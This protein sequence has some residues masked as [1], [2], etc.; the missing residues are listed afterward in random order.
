M[1]NEGRGDLTNKTKQ[2]IRYSYFVHWPLV[3]RSD[4]EAFGLDI[5]KALDP[6]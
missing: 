1:K 4:R 6:E 2:T 5:G 3:Q